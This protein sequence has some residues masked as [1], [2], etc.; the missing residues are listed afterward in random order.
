MIAFT[1]TS[2]VHPAIVTRQQLFPQVHESYLRVS[3]EGAPTWIDDPEGAT[4]FASMREAA[5]MA[6]RLP[7]NLKA[8]GLPLA[9]RPMD[10]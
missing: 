1:Q 4:A 9:S 8:F 2:H 6:S 5:R 3:A 7:A 10:A